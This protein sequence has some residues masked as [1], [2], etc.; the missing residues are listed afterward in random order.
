[1]TEQLLKIIF[2]H[3]VLEKKCECSETVY[4]LFTDLL[5]AYESG[6]KYCALF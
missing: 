1:V 3:K 5:K 2:I 4:L 6:R